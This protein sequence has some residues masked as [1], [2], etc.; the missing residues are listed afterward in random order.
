MF[1]P[2]YNIIIY[3]GFY[4][5]AASCQV[6]F[7]RSATC[8]RFLGR[9]SLPSCRTRARLP[10]L[11]RFQSTDTA[12]SISPILLKRARSIAEEHAKLSTQNAENYDVATAK[13]IG[14]LSTVTAALAEWD[15][16][17]NVIDALSLLSTLGLR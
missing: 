15:T 5:L 6:M 2:I 12:S 13:K 1:R 4:G 9:L 14:E 3:S 11:E 16:A 7:V 17:Q 10:R 8:T